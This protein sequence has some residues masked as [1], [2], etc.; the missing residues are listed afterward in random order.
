MSISVA[1]SLMARAV[2]TVFTSMRLCDEGNEPLT[3]AISTPSTSSVSATVRA[4]RG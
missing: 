2:S 4:K 1:P 3:Q